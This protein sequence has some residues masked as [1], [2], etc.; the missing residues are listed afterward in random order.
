MKRFFLTTKNRYGWSISTSIPGSA[1]EKTEISTNHEYAWLVSGR[2]PISYVSPPVNTINPSITGIPQEGQALT[3]SYGAWSG[4]PAPSYAQQWKRNGVNI[5]DATGI[6]YILAGVDVGA[7]ITC[8]VTATN[9]SGSASATSNALGP[10]AAMPVG[11]PVNS[12]APAISGTPTVGQTLSTSSG[13]W[14]N[15][16]TGYTYQWRRNG[17]AISGANFST[18]NLGSVDEGATITALVTASNAGGSSAAVSEGVGP[19]AAAPVNEIAW[20]P[21]MMAP[22]VWLDASDASTMRNVVG[23]QADVGES[24]ETWQDKSGNNNHAVS[25]ANSAGASTSATRGVVGVPEVLGL[26]TVTPLRMGNGVLTNRY[27]TPAGSLQ[28]VSG[29]SGDA[30][31]VVA[32]IRPPSTAVA[33]T[34]IGSSQGSFTTHLGVSSSAGAGQVFAGSSAGIVKTDTSIR[35]DMLSQEKRIAT[36]NVFNG[37]LN[38]SESLSPDGAGGSL[39]ST[40]RM[41][42]GNVYNGSQG[43]D[44]DIL[45]VVVPPQGYSRLNMQRLEGYYAHRYGLPLP[46]GHPFKDAPPMVPVGTTS[47]VGEVSVLGA[48]AQTWSV[49]YLSEMQTDSFYGGQQPLPSDDWAYPRDFT[50]SELARFKATFLP[51][52]GYGFHGIRLALE[53][54]AHHRARETDSE[55]GLIKKTGFLNGVLASIASFLSNVIPEGGGVY[56]GAW[57]FPPWFKTNPNSGISQY[58]YG[59]LWAGGTY[60]RNVSLSSI[61]TTDPTQFNTQVGLIT[62]YF[63]DVLEYIHAVVPVRG[64]EFFNEAGNTA[65]AIYGTV[66]MDDEVMYT[67]IIKRGIEKI[68]S[69]AALSTWGGQPNSVIFYANNW[70]GL[71]GRGS[72]L[73]SDAEVLS[74]GKTAWQEIALVT[75]HSITANGNDADAVKSKTTLIATNGKPFCQNEMEHFNTYTDP[76]S[77]SYKTPQ[78]RAMNLALK[79]ANYIV[80]GGAIMDV[81][82][83]HF[84]KPIGQT[85]VDSNTEGYGLTQTRLPSPYSQAP[86]T[87]GDTHP[88]IGHGAWGEIAVNAMGVKP[89]LNLPK[90]SVI[91]KLDGAVIAG[92]QGFGWRSPNGKIGRLFVNRTASASPKTLGIPS[93][94]VMKGKRYSYDN[95]EQDLGT[96]NASRI[97]MELPSWSCEVW[98]EQ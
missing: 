15:S 3:L 23:D 53:G 31:F 80:V 97:N 37:R 62:D 44:G 13:T 14:S 18:Y 8:E 7:N 60:A 81:P 89:L 73:V 88:E 12:V 16:P 19:V 21:Q 91:F 92:Q 32:R 45:A 17:V 54:F 98:M 90:G 35:I 82:I 63:V 2:E 59:T 79:T 29:Q 20:M 40:G 66:H 70:D 42:I 49:G 65:N 6:T 5:S 36:G 67:T 51:G 52:G 56:P 1:V 84:T 78:F 30:V 41:A 46:V 26:T 39:A 38:G 64:F 11:A 22:R 55:T 27:L 85:D 87:P 28:M 34:L 61:R 68:R 74:T 72:S 75:D 77:G 57:G 4:Y 48:P 69:S 83:I 10:V 25:A 9:T 96:I 58:G 95:G 86:T 24:V 50:P 47:T 93:A 94:K 71:Q 33:R 43:V 76:A